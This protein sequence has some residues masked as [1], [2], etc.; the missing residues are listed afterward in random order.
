MT[1]PMVAVKIFQSTLPRGERQQKQTT[2]YCFSCIII[3]YI[4]KNI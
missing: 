2:F 3:L 4:H 1:V